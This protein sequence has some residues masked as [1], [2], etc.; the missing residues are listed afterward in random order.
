MSLFDILREDNCFLRLFSLS[1]SVYLLL[2]IIPCAFFL[3]LE[4]DMANP[5]HPFSQFSTGFIFSTSCTFQVDGLVCAHF[6]R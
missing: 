2:T 6:L 4:R 3:Q 1:I 5:Q